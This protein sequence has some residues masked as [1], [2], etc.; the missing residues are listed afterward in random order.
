VGACRRLFCQRF[1]VERPGAVGAHQRC[2]GP[3]VVSQA[4]VQRGRT[5]MKA[6]RTEVRS[7]LTLLDFLSPDSVLGSALLV[8]PWRTSYAVGTVKHG[9]IAG[10][11][12][13]AKVTRCSPG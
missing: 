1:L 12:P 11:Q 4:P 8:H 2:C 10:R 13:E 9:P 7:K 6:D 5:V 3:L